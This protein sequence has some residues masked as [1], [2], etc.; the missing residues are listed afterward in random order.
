MPFHKLKIKQKNEI[1]TL[2]T[3]FSDPEKLSGK[4]IKYDEWNY[5][6]KD[7]ET[8]VIDVR[9]EF[10]VKIGTF[11]GSINPKTKSFTEFKSFVKNKL[12]KSKNKK[13]AMF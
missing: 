13:I 6:I 4:R 10:E 7:K 1:V 2:R 8:I 5:L 9:N 11:E 3:K 12:S